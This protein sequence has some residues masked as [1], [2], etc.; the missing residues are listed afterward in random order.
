MRV[1]WQSST[2]LDSPKMADY[3]AHLVAHVES[4]KRPDTEIRFSGV[5]SG[6][7]ALDYEA[8]VELNSMAVGGVL[9]KIIQADAE[10][11]D[12]VAIGCM[13]DPALLQARELVDIP[14]VSFGEVTLLVACMLGDR[15]SGVAFSDK[16][17][18]RYTRQA[19]EMGLRDRVAPFESLGIDFPTLAASF[20]EPDAMVDSFRQSAR[21]LIAQGVEVIIPA[22]ATLDLFLAEARI[23][24]IDGA[25][26]LH[27]NS[28]LMKMAESFADLAQLGV[29]TS[30][31]L[32]YAGPSGR[33]REEILATYG[34][35]PLVPTG[36]R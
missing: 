8:V 7:L 23:D 30:R 33:R 15:V 9:H 1:W 14:I 26:V 27:A 16:Q 12:V 6:S 21:R 29:T 34:I 28:T 13:L 2:P 32:K 24:E 19:Y 20:R 3:R 36:S 18:G 10:G 5:D 11:Y 35:T 4:V 17:A 22:C 25:R 31:A